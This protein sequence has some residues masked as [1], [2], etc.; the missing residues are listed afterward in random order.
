M[1]TLTRVAHPWSRWLAR[2]SPRVPK[3]AGVWQR[4]QDWFET[5]PEPS[6]RHRLGSWTRLR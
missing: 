1:S 5:L 6:D 2:R 4:L 3:R